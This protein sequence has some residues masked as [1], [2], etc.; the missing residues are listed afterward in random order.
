MTLPVGMNLSSKILVNL[1][2]IKQNEKN[3]KEI[4]KLE[5]EDEQD[6][7][8]KILINQIEVIEVK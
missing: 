4:N 6:D 3:I 7:F 5:F 1:S 8:S 2:D